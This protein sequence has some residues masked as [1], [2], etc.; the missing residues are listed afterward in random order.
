M[1]AEGP[2]AFNSG[3][4]VPR[5]RRAARFETSA[6]ESMQLRKDSLDR[7]G[8]ISILRFHGSVG[9]TGS[10]MRISKGASRFRTNYGYSFRR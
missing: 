6:N 10:Q 7:G 2:C 5:R 8:V 4:T 1:Q 9:R 3:A